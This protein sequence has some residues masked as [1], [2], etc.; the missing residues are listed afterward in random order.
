MPPHRASNPLIVV[1]VVVAILLNFLSF[2][3]VSG[4]A[5]VAP[6]KGTMV[7]DGND[8]TTM[9][10]TAAKPKPM[11]SFYQRKLP[12]TCVAFSSKVGKKIFASALAH[13]G[14]KSF[15]PLIQQL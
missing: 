8:T 13:N 10:S 7:A 6:K 4:L 14:L 5:S 1:V 15:F 2:E 3:A 9:Q 12:D 11:P